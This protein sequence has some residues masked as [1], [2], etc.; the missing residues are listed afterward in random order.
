MVVCLAIAVVVYVLSLGPVVLFVSKYGGRP[1]PAL[2]R[3]YYPLAWA[4]KNCWPLE[5]AVDWY[6]SMWH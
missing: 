1:S 5:E 6:V 2:E 4:C 3:L